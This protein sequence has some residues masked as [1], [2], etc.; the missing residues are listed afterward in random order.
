MNNYITDYQKSKNA[1]GSGL[2][3]YMAQVYGH[4][5]L[6]LFTTALGAL[7]ALT[8]E[9]MGQLFFQF[10]A[11]G[12][13]IGYTGFG[14]LVS[15]APF[16][17]AMYLS[18]KVAQ[19]SFTHSRWLF[20]G[21]AFLTGI[22]FSCLAFYYTIDSLHK[23]FLIAAITFGSMSIFGYTTHRD[24]T[25]VGAFCRTAIWGLMIS[26]LVNLFLKSEAIDFVTSF[27]G[28][29]AFT[30][31]IAYQTQRLKTLYYEMQ[32]TAL[33]KK[34]GLMAAFSLYINFLNLFLYLL[35]FFGERRRK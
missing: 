22:S 9:P 8:I 7:L 24:L 18:C 4:V 10:D 19:L 28:V 5:A 30:S 20:L 13:F 31:L 17:M 23:T 25:S 26:T 3:R 29:I 32:E 2:Q 34:V 6:A 33:A 21:Y 11:F 35:R 27:I 16:L 1:L 12:Q 15:F 14:L